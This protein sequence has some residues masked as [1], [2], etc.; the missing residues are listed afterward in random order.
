MP[1]VTG[2]PTVPFTPRPRHPAIAGT[3]KFGAGFITSGFLT[4]RQSVTHD[5][6]LRYPE[7]EVSA[8]RQYW[9]QDRL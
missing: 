1:R 4:V 2:E 6:I 9:L 3:E 7:D 5:S 8:G